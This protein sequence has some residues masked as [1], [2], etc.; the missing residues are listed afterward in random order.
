LKLTR[1]RL[2][3]AHLGCEHVI[4]GDE[5]SI[6]EAPSTFHMGLDGSDLI[7]CERRHLFGLECLQVRVGNGHDDVVSGGA[8][9][10]MGGVLA[11]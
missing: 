2:G 10:V 5:L 1:A 9:L 8:L 3:E 4:A 7:R 11:E 6:E